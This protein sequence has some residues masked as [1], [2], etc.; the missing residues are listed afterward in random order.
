MVRRS[1]P[2]QQPAVK[3]FVEGGGDYGDLRAECRQGFSTFIARAGLAGHMPRVVACGSRRSAY[4]DFCTALKNPEP[5][6]TYLLFVDSE[7]PINHGDSKWAHLSVR[8]G[9]KWACPP[10]ADEASVFLMVEAMESWLLADKKTLTEYYGQGFQESALPTRT[11]V[12]DISKAELNRSLKRATSKTQKGEYNKGSH[13]F[14]LISKLDPQLIISASPHA[15][16][17]IQ[18]LRLLFNC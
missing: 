10:D 16:D 11:N 3:V 12:E 14:Q 5:D 9:D 17:F 4:E 6:T 13:S 8:E 15:A 1:K 7:A 18:R 2:T